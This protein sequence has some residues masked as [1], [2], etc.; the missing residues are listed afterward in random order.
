MLSKFV[1]DTGKD[2][3]KWL[4]FLLFAYC[5]VPQASTGFAPFELLFAHQM[6]GPLDVLKDSRE[7]NNKSRK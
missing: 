7:A 6:S 3:D 5:E 2:W 4:L 1:S